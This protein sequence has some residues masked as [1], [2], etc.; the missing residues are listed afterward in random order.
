MKPRIDHRSMRFRLILTIGLILLVFQVIS[1]AWLWHESKEQIQFLVEAQLQKRNMDRHVEREVHEAVAS[2]AVPS[3]VMISLTLLLCYQAVKWITRPLYQLQRELENR[4]EENL[5]PIACHS[6]VQEIDAVTQA[7]NQ[8]VARLNN[9]LERERLFTADV[10]HEL[11]TPLAGLRLHLELIERNSD[12]NVQ[13]LLQRL[14]QMTNSVSQLLQ[15]ARAG[16][17]FTSG[18][19]QNVALI[20]DVI[21]PME[22]ELSTMLDAH[23]QTLTL[24]LPQDIF[25]RGDATL[26]KML[27]RNLVENAHRYSPKKSAITLRLA[28]GEQ[29]TLTVEDEG[30]GIDE[31]KSGELSKAFIRMDSRYGGIGLGLSIV[32]RIV[33]LHRFQF[34]LENR[35]DRSGCRAVIKF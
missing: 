16:Q 13:P 17:S 24:D 19:Y 7:I 32:S 22:A 4:S 9:S 26:L 10:A 3:L 20:E 1:V 8:L 28:S 30:P 5:D 15:L 23:Q 35:R 33:Q 6:P 27:L 25:V 21:L 14:D 2:L 31:S 11:R 29:P 12:V 18:T 34:F